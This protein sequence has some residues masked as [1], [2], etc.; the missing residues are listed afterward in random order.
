MEWLPIR[1]LVFTW[2]NTG[3]SPPVARLKATS[4]DIE[5]V[6]AQVA[7]MRREHRFAVLGLCEVQKSD[8]DIIMERVADLDLSLLDFSDR[9]GMLKH[10]TALIYD[11]TALTYI[12]KASFIERFGK[13]AMKLGELAIFATKEEQQAVHVVV[14]HWPSRQTVSEH[15]SRKAELGSL[16]RQSLSRIRD[17]DGDSH[18][19]LMGDYNDDPFS[20]SLSGH[21][22][23]TRDRE[24]A[25]RDS[26]F[27]YNPFWRCLGESRSASTASDPSVCGTH[28]YASGNDTEWFT[29]DQIIFSSAFLADGPI[30]L[31][32][33]H[34]RILVSA[35]LK[36][37]IHTKS[38][39]CD[40]LPVTSAVTLRRK[41]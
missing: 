4:D 41:S 40:H 27:L 17:V 16:L 39:T 11:R 33:E 26:R 24:L 5:F 29:Y 3:L 10:D 19:V 18:I 34:T 21:L 7:S 37:R 25:R 20:P 35:E 38:Q 31:N 8:L 9:T 2:W 36:S 15:E 14:S 32:E 6:A 1:P 28:Y 13:R 23:A 22:L 30:T 12:D